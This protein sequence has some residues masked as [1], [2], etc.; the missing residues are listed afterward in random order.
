MDCG[1]DLLAVDDDDHEDEDDH[2]AEDDDDH[3]NDDT[4]TGEKARK[5]G[6]LQPSTL[7]NSCGSG[8]ISSISS[9]RMKQTSGR[10]RRQLCTGQIG[11]LEVRFYDHLFTRHIIFGEMTLSRRTIPFHK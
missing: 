2:E 9:Q 7:G 3:E 10:T 11:R 8:P 1:D 4:A 5:I 6:C